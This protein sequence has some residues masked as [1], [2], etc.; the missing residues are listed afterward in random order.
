ME[1]QINPDSSFGKAIMAIAADPAYQTFLDIGTW[2]G[3]GTTRCLVLATDERP[4]TMI[5]SIEAN[6]DM[7]NEAVANWPDPPSNLKLLYGRVATEM[8]SYTNITNSP[9]FNDIETHFIL[10]Y[11]QDV[12]DFQNA[13]LVE[14]PA[15]I[16]VAILDGGEFCGGADL[17]RVVEL[18]PKIIALDDTR[19]MK[20]NSN[21]A[22]L[23][24]DPGWQLVEKS[25]D[26]NGW[27][28]F[29]KVP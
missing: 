3:M 6:R 25:D 24:A 14:L 18:S 15:Q 21:L 28:I 4:G 2:N 11:G 5:Y 7:F 1:G 27:A 10:H 12:Y 16:D 13:P 20:N 8:L 22:L 26:R 19:C 23:S 9:N 29:K 17:S